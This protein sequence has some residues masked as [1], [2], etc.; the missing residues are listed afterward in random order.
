MGGSL[1]VAY[2]DDDDDDEVALGRRQPEPLEDSEEEGE[3]EVE[4]VMALEG[5]DD[6]DDE[7]EDDDDDEEE[8]D[9][10]DEEYEDGNMANGLA[11]ADDDE[12]DEDDD[13]DEDSAR[14]GALGWGA[15]RTDLYGGHADAPDEEDDDLSEDEQAEQLEAKE[16]LRLQKAHAS[17]LRAEDFGELTPAEPTRGAAGRSERAR[18]LDDELAELP[19]ALRDAGGVRLEAVAR[20]VSGLSEAAVA[21]AVE[22]DAPELLHLLAD[23]KETLREARERVAPLLASARQKQLPPEGG[24]QLLQVKLQLMLSYATNISF[25]LLLKAQGRTVRDHPVIDALL[26]HRILLERL[27]PLEAKQSYR[28]S[29]MLQLAAASGE[30]GEGAASRLG[31]L[32]E[33]PNPHALL[34][35]KGGGARAQADG[36][37][38]DEEE[39][40]AEGGDGLY[41]PPKLAAVPY[42]DEPG[43]AK[44]ERQKQRALAR[45]SSSR[46]V[47]ELRE[48]LSDAPRAIHADDFGGAVDADSAAVARLREEESARRAYEEDNFKRLRLTKEQKRAQRVRERA[49]EGSAFDELGTFDDFSHLYDVAKGASEPVA[50]ARDEKMRALRQ[51]MNSIEQ[52]GG[53]N[54]G[55]KKHRSADDDAPSRRREERAEKHAQRAAREY[56]GDGD[57]DGDGDGGGGGGGKK[58]GRRAPPP[59]EDPFYTEMAAAAQQKKHDKVGRRTAAKEAAAEAIRSRPAD[60]AAPGSKREIN[61]AIEKN[62]GLTRERKKIDAN[63]RVK[64]REKFRKA[65]IRRK[66]AVR[67]VQDAGAGPYS[68]ELT[69]IKK[70]VTHSTR[71]K[72]R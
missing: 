17:R 39:D 1:D 7:E 66:G 30:G 71:F 5:M 65:T 25:Y 50:D 56:G 10:D 53:A 18:K 35:K 22:A 27:R 19:F 6:D 21:R 13:E 55:Q 40:E 28:L 12:S 20:D 54:P 36:S 8:E 3:E 14:P 33:R 49:A 47:R 24:V 52:R 63:P 62:R 23:F 38:D 68:G 41:R 2:E 57:G 58:R 29:K 31:D 26:R 42:D 45:A 69:G 64:N 60:E 9:D 4:E 15:R 46:L 43:G 44:R 11:R 70:N 34:A 51:Y 37:D 59:E 32:A 48:E 61:R 67:G 72:T 16:A